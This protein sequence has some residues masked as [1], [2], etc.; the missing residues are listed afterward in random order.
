[1]PGRKSENAE[2]YINS[3][4]F[5]FMKR[6]AKDLLCYS[7]FRYL[8]NDLPKQVGNVYQGAFQ[9]EKFYRAL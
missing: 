6:L 3:S 5:L 2:L 9:R 4:I 7:F 1:M 8:T